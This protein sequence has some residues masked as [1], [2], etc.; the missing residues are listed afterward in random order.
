MLVNNNTTIYSWNLCQSTNTGG[1]VPLDL[2]L[3]T[4]YGQTIALTLAVI[5]D[6]AG[7]SNLFLDDISLIELTFADVPYGYWA[8][9]YIQ[10]LYNAGVTGGC[11]TSPLMY[12]PGNAVTRDQMAVFLLRA[13]HGSSYVPPAVG[14]STGF[15]DVPIDYWAA[16]WIKQLAAE[17]IT[18]G[19]GNGNYCPSSSVTRDQ[20]AVFLLRGEHGSSYVPPAPSGMFADVPTNYWA[21]PWIEQ[22]AVEGITGGCGGGNYCPSNTVTRDQMAIFLVRAFSLP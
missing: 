15:N 18:G 4:Y 11:A 1:W 3:S 2:N 10:R 9:S 16:A 17:G 12:C 20:M 7:I 6:E 19:C 5:T 22:L 13:K 14:G 8:E 21:A